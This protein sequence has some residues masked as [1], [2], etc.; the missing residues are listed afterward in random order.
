V[1][2][3]AAAGD[4]PSDIRPHY[5]AVDYHRGAEVISLDKRGWR[6]LC[7]ELPCPTQ[8]LDKVR[9]CCLVMAEGI[10]VTVGHKTTHFKTQ[11]H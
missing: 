7:R 2:R 5:G 10:I 1:G 9:R 4:A 11:R 8:V 3:A 6:R